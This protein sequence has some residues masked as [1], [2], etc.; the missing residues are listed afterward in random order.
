VSK[1]VV[2]FKLEEEIYLKLRNIAK[3][4][5]RGISEIVREALTEW[6]GKKNSASASDF[7]TFIREQ[8]NEGKT[9][10]EI[11]FLVAEK[12]SISLSKEQLKSLSRID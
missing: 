2:T 6:L 10:A 8:K 9:W 7:I 1:V 5:G 12:Y 11:A 4:E 3:D